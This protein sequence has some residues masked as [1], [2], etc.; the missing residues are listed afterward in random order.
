MSYILCSKILR[1]PYQDKYLSG[2]L[3]EAQTRHFVCQGVS[4][5]RRIY[6]SRIIPPQA[7]HLG[8]VAEI[9]KK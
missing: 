9:Q 3:Q 2:S 8:I 1:F 4:S 5:T 6:L 7:P